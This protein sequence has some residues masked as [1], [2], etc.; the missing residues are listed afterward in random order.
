[1]VIRIECNAMWRMGPVCYLCTYDLLS[2]Y[3]YEAFQNS[4]LYRICKLMTYT[5][6]IKLGLVLKFSAIPLALKRCVSGF[7][8]RWK[9]CASRQLM[10]A[11]SHASD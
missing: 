4:T 6:I 2:R 3:S 9:L 1:M 7:I 10:P 11:S 5:S 8:F